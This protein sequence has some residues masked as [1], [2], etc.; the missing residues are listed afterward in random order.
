MYRTAG[1]DGQSIFCREAG[2]ADAPV[3][4]LLHGF[5]T[6]S[7]MF[8]NAI[9]ALADW[10]HLVTPDYPGYGNSSMPAPDESDYTFDNA[11]LIAGANHERA[12]RSDAARRGRLGVRG[13]TEVLTGSGL[14]RI[15]TRHAALMGGRSA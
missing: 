11:A 7:H 3:L 4:L 8:R 15:L 13:P 2:L 5:P 14:C 12:H 6:S 9:P 10:F 1:I